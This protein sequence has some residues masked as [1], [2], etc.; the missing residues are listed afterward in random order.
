M[1]LA[2]TFA[3]AEFDYCTITKKHTMC[4]TDK[5]YGPKCGTVLGS[6]I[7]NREEQE[8]IQAEFSCNLSEIRLFH[9]VNQYASRIPKIYC[10]KS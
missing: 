7:T 8:I 9:R 6:G 10:I 2:V 5:G 3:K 1:V 4:G